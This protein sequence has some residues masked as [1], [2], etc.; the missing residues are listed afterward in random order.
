MAASKTGKNAQ[1]TIESKPAAYNAAVRKGRAAVASQGKFNW[2]LGDLALTVATTYG[3]STIT[4]FADDLAVND[5]T[6][7]DFRNVARAYPADRRGVASWTVHQILS[8][9]DDRFELVQQE[10]TAAAARA[11]VQSRKGDD[12]VPDGEGDSDGEGAGNDQP[13][14]L[15][16]QLAKAKA[17]VTR[18]EGELAKAVAKVEKITAEMN[19]EIQA[20]QR[21]RT[22]RAPRARKPAAGKR[23]LASVA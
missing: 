14:D 1:P 6:L 17:E 5:K 3:D 4:R 12:E 19:A 22:P 16:T 18:I 9:L 13:D 21:G 7:Y 10:M 23:Q 8:K 11:I 15:T 2:T 20:A